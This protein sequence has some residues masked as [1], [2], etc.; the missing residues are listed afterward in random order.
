MTGALPATVFALGFSFRKR[1]IVRRFLGAVEVRFV[2]HSRRIPSGAALLLWGSRPLPA[3]LPLDCRVI[4]LEDGFLRSVGLGADLIHPVSWVIDQTG[5]Y[6]DAQRPSDLEN[7]LLNTEFTVPLLARAASLRARIVHS[8]LTKYNLG[9]LQWTRP[10]LQNPHRNVILVPGQ[11]ET[12]ASIYFGAVGVRTNLDLL[13]AVRRANPDA[14][15]VYKP[16]P[17]VVA[18]L[19]AKGKGES[20]V[21]AWCDE[22]VV[23]AAI[24][25]MLAVVDEVH[26][27]TSLTGF[28][29]LLRGKKVTCYGQ[30][31]YAGWGLTQDMVPVQRRGRQLSLDALVAATL[32]LYPTYVGRHSGK[33][34]TPELALDELLAWRTLEQTSTNVISEMS[35]WRKIVRV[36]LRI[37]GR[38]L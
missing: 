5:I 23:D 4:R 1:A 25:E 32:L 2:R 14:Y 7:L 33:I 6:Y 8:G 38:N 11:V 28:E 12:D 9:S 13:Q 21:A 35:W 22:I 20:T 15:I 27:M 17:D 16:H 34:T 30:P 10:S 37:R 31:F 24:Q 19:R 29:A 26:V 3:S 36:G 18:G